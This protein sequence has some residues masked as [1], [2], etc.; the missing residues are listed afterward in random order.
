[1][2]RLFVIATLLGAAPAMADEG[3]WTYNNFP[4][5][6]VKE[7]YGFE[8]SQQWLDNARLSSARLAGGCSAS[9]VSAN[10]LVM[11]NHHCA[12]GC[13]DQLSTAKKNYIANGFYAKTQA[14]ETQCPAMEINQ[15]VKITDVTETLN[16][17]TQGL[18]GKKYADTLKAK[19]SELE[20]ACSAGNAKARCDVVTLYQGG[21]YNLY[22][23]KRFQDVRLVMAPEHAIAFFGG[24]PD[25]FEFPRYDLDVTFLRVYEDGKPATTN[26]FFKWSDKGA[27]EGELTFISG[28][29]GRTSRGLTVAELEF[30]RDVQLPK[31]LMMLSEMR[32]MLTEFGRRGAEQRRISTNMLFGVENAV[33]ALKGRHEALLDKAFFAQKVAAE[34]ELRKKVNANPEMKKKYGA[35]W[36]EI[37]KAQTELRNIRKD[38]AFMENGSGL[39]S[40]LFSLARTLVRGAEELNKPNGER[41]RE[42]NQANVPALEAQ[43]FSPAPIY[44][45]LEIARLTFGLTKMREELGSDHPFVKKV[46]GKESPEKLAARL[47]KGT[48]LRDVKARQALYKGGKAAIAASKD[49]M[50][51]LAAALDPDMRAVRKSYEENVESVIRKNSELVA[52]AKFDIYGTNQYPDATFSLRLSYGAVKG[53]TENGKQVSPIT[54][55]AGTFAHATGEEPFAL[56]KSWLKNEKALDGTTPMNFVSTNDIIGGNSGSPVINKDAE[57]VGIVFD[58]NIHSL[59]GEYGFDESVNRSVSVHSAAIIESLTKIYGAT[60]LLEELRPGSTKVPPVKASPAK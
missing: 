41:L 13:I 8:P 52:K 45:E 12:R 1:M 60:R 28:H 43:L 26:N 59:G 17:A 20:Q 6:K 16:K 58:G 38:L 34:Q 54:Q 39:S 11:T 37:A 32:G 3:M 33:K 42:F 29:P 18:T 47:V 2:K 5:A 24:D 19:M 21:Q 48:R 40:T 22:E 35:A 44:P 30:H 46:L 55:M 49:P 15:L 4:S 9:F 7:K 50:I 57:I 14:A 25:N 23:Y 36:D 56:P 51:Q 53:Y 31:T 27:K 10:G